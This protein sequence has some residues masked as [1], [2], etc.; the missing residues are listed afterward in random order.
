MVK[1]IK[2]ALPVVFC[3]VAI[4]GYSQED[5]DR[6]AFTYDLYDRMRSGRVFH[7]RSYPPPG[8]SYYCPNCRNF[9]RYQTDYYD[10]ADQGF[11]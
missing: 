2:I 6:D 5:I 1:I 4:Q 7:D 3:F 11:D 9:H 10:P 8:S